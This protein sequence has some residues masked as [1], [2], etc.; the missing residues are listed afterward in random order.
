[1]INKKFIEKLKDDYS[2]STGERKQIIALANVVLHDSKRVIFALHRGDIKKAEENFK[3]IEKVL[4]KLDE[5]FGH[6]RVYQEGSYKAGV[7]E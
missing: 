6:K 4:S 2:T 1:M 3:E 7:E 5:E